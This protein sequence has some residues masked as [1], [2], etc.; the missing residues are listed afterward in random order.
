MG[1]WKPQEYD[2]AYRIW[3]RAT[4]PDSPFDLWLDPF[5]H[6]G[7][8]PF[9][10]GWLRAAREGLLIS[11]EHASKLL[12]LKT[13][14]GFGKLEKMELN[15]AITIETLQKAAEALG[16]ELVYAI[17]PKSRQR[18]SQVIWAEVL[19]EAENHSW[20]HYAPKQM[21][22][23]ALAKIAKDRT[24]NPK[25]RRKKNWKLRDRWLPQ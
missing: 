22:G 4:F 10:K 23:Q 15:G 6:P 12:G 19:P 14:T 25:F 8:Q 3:R 17:R 24:S 18:F 11:G 9:K 1:Q 7:I 21:K 20:V 5:N 2:L 13:R 16:C